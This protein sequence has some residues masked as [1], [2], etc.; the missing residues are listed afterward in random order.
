[1]AVSVTQVGKRSVFGDRRVV[2]ADLAFSGNYATG[3][4]ALSASSF[5]LSR[6]DALVLPGAAVAA[7]E[8][9]AVVI[10]YDYTGG[11]VVAYEGSTAGTA[12][13]EKTNAEAWPTG[14]YARCIAIGA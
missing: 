8:A 10:A 7:D 11:K 3:G 6:L 2:V 1:M 4:E 5:G 12:L 14:A 9:T 13:S